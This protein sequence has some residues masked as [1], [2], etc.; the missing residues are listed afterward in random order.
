[1]L[2]LCV[3]AAL[4]LVG[5]AGAQTKT[6]ITLEE[7]IALARDKSPAMLATRSL[8]DQARAQEITANL[9]PNPTVAWDSQ[10]LPVFNPNN[11]TSSTLNEVSQ[12]DVGLGYLFERGHKRQRRLQV[13]QNITEVTRA[14]VRDAERSLEFNVAQQFIAALVAQAN[15]EVAQADLKS[16][17]NTVAI[18]E[19]RYKAGDISQGDFL[20][21]K[22][23]TLQFQNDV[24]AAQLAKVEALASLRQLVGT[25]NLPSDYEVAGELAYEALTSSLDALRA[26]ALQQRPDLAAAQR[27]IE[28]TRS[29][30]RLARANSKQDLNASFAYSHTSGISS[31]SMAFNVPIPLF[32][33]NQGEVARTRFAISQAQ[34]NATA[35]SDIVLRD[36][37]TVYE[38]V[39]TQ[40]Q[41][42]RLYTSGYLNQ[43]QQSR[44]ISE[45]AY[46][47]GAVALLDLLD[48]ER[49]Y[50]AVQ[51]GYRQALGNYLLA[52]EQLRAAVG[53]RTLP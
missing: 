43:A 9:R 17:Q 53:T 20:K 19:T 27:N 50:R 34:Q 51:L 48:A 1:V 10:F 21:I 42:V 28:T 11:F 23:Q 13:A 47:Q 32:N 7:A 30:Y 40:E 41:I 2:K 6:K 36:V 16:F 39:K 4:V 37:E 14:Q 8:I 44:D 52:L 24:S 31:S 33:R 38:A 25:N 49:S 45:Y 18:S 35:A 15:L 3:A 26:T 12:F 46:R 5:V 22:L 29:Q